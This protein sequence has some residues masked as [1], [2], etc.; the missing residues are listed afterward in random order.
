MEQV[1]YVAKIVYSTSVDGVGLRNSLYVSGCPLRCEGCHNQAFWDIQSGNKYTVEEV[2]QQLN[3][4]DFNI[5]ILGGEPMM[6]Y[7]SIVALCK[8]IKE[9]YPHKTIWLWSGY[10][11]EHIKKYYPTI[12]QYIDV[13]IDGKYIQE[14]TDPSLKWRGSS[15]QRIIHL[16]NIQ[17]LYT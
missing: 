14:L 10:T 12:L 6:Q 7:E 5:S 15:N 4:D 9:N 8:L 2:F 11:F 13:L 16:N 3:I 1:I 17:S